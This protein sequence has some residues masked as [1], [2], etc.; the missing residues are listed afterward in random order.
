MSATSTP[1]AGVAG[2]PP[3]RGAGV[4]GR[5]EHRVHVA[6]RG[7][8]RPAWSPG[9]M[10]AAI[11]SATAPRVVPMRRDAEKSRLQPRSGRVGGGRATVRTIHLRHRVHLLVG[12]CA[13]PGNR[14]V[15]GSGSRK[16]P[17]FA[18]PP[19]DGFAEFSDRTCDSRPGCRLSADRCPAG[20]RRANGTKVLFGASQEPTFR[21]AETAAQL[22]L[23]DP[24][25]AVV[26][27]VVSVVGS[28]IRTLPWAS[29]VVDRRPG[30]AAARSRSPG[31]TRSRGSA[32]G[33][34][35]TTARRPR[36]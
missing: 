30:R 8:S 21:S 10:A 31:R 1:C 36:R 3:R 14:A 33:R 32:A 24:A 17:G 5:V 16:I 18:S 20:P 27:R 7:R 26:A 13:V 25:S 29:I 2:V 22:G 28:P 12:R 35:A 11:V 19:L 4:G 6:T 34:A 15:I 9:A 23:D